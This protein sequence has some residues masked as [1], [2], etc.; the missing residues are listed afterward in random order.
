MISTDFS[1]SHIAAAALNKANTDAGTAQQRISTSLKINSAKDD[2]TGYAQATKLKAQI[3]S[4]GKAIDNIN[5]GISLVQSVDDSMGQVTEILVKMREL[6]V[7]AAGES[8]ATTRATYQTTFASYL[9]DITNVVG[10][11]TFNS[12]SVMDGSTTSVNVQTGIDASQ[13]K[14]LTFSDMSNT[15]LGIA[16][17]DLSTSTAD[18]STAITTIDTAITTATAYLTTVGAYE[19]SL[20]FSSDLANENIQNKSGQYGDLMNADLAQEATNLAAAQIRQSSA[21]AMVAQG[22]LMNREMVGYLLRPYTG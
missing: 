3:G 12:S 14:T 5:R 9:T 4:Y 17:V 19:D 10:R 21:A 6:A 22:N 7:Q 13:T 18:A 11:T 8:N 20:S 16:A 1:N 15:G 2:P